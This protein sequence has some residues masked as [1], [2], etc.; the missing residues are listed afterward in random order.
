MAGYPTVEQSVR[1]G[2]RAVDSYQAV[3]NECLPVTLTAD[4]NLKGFPGYLHNFVAT[5]LSGS[6]VTVTLINAASGSTPVVATI[7]V[8]ANSTININ[9][10]WFFDTA[11]RVTCSLWTSVT[12]CGGIS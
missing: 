9:P 3:R 8:P 12:V 7:A 1:P 11:I 6:A 5:N 2:D 10:G 4:G